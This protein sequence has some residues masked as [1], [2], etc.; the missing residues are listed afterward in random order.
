VQN[1]KLRGSLTV[2]PPFVYGKVDEFGE[3]G[4]YYPG[5]SEVDIVKF[6]KSAMVQ[7]LSLREE[8]TIENAN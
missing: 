1:A 8:K 7:S 3:K 5:M 4:D 6:S 2:L